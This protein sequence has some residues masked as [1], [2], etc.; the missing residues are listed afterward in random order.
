MKAVT[1]DIEIRK[2]NFSKG[3]YLVLSVLS[4]TAFLISLK[5]PENTKWICL[6]GLLLFGSGYWMALKAKIKI[7]YDGFTVH[8]VGKSKFVA[9]KDI[10]ALDYSSFYHGHGVEMR[11]TVFYGSPAKKIEFPVKQYNKQKMQRFFEILHEQCLSALKNDHF[12]KQSTGQMNW[13][14]KLKMY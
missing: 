2:N 9:W 14:G 4:F 11:L 13:K 10:T 1:E 7:A 3:L 12:I 8:G 5:D 6:A